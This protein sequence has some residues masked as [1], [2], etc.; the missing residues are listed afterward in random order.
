MKINKTTL[1]FEDL[2]QEERDELLRLAKDI[3][4]KGIVP[5]WHE[6]PIIEKW[7]NEGGLDKYQYLLFISTVFPS[8]ALLAVVEYDESRKHK[9]EKDALD[10]W[11]HLRWLATKGG[12]FAG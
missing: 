9:K 5:P 10:E 8:R 3:V 1:E 7:M 11:T 12:C 4:R 2:N 6:N